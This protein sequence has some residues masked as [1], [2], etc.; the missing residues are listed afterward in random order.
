MK[1]EIIILKAT[2]FDG[3]FVDPKTRSEQKIENSVKIFC[4]GENFEPGRD[5]IVSDKST[6]EKRGCEIQEFKADSFVYG[7]IEN[8]KFPLKAEI[9]IEIRR[10]RMYCVDIKNPK[11]VMI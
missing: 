9:D 11:P 10:N 5:D 6:F 1:K 3:I 4:M 2:K 8:L 7:Q